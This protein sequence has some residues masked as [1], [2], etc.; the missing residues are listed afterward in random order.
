[1]VG[2]ILKNYLVRQL[3]R[4]NVGREEAES[5]IEDIILLYAADSIACIDDNLTTNVNWSGTAVKAAYRLGRSLGSMFSDISF[6]VAILDQEMSRGR[7][8]EASIAENLSKSPS[9]NVR[10]IAS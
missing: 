3:M 1:M 9:S 6:D 5:R 10:H 2:S 4:K 8:D 7:M